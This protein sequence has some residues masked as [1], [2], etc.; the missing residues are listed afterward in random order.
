VF[1]ARISR[2]AVLRQIS[3]LWALAAGVE[4]TRVW[5]AS[6][7][8]LNDSCVA[9]DVAGTSGVGGAGYSRYTTSANAAAATLGIREAARKYQPIWRIGLKMPAVVYARGL[10]PVW[11]SVIQDWNICWPYNMMSMGASD[12]ET[13]AWLSAF[14]LSH[15]K[16]DLGR[17]R[18]VPS[19]NNTGG[20]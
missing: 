15:G 11:R 19:D 5:I 3:V 1:R 10:L 9:S 12:L 18:T 16:H 2:A 7:T 17:R 8:M 4:A 14:C 6:F 20:L 13:W